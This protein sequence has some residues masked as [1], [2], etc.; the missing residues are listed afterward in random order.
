MKSINQESGIYFFLKSL[1]K[2]SIQ[3]FI[4][5]SVENGGE[6]RGGAGGWVGWGGGLTYY[7]VDFLPIYNNSDMKQE[8]IDWTGEL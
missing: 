7:Q 1:N 8:Y 4:I 6:E 5:R 3:Y 2:Q